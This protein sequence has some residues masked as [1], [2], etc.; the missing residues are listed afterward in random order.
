MVTSAAPPADSRSG[1]ERAPAT[2]EDRGTRGWARGV[3]G[4]GLT[5]LLGAPYISLE[6]H[7]DL[8]DLDAIHEEVCLAV[9]QVPVAYTGGSH[10]SMGIMPPGR[11]S[12]A[13]RDYGEVI[14][15]LDDLQRSTL[16]GLADFPREFAARLAAG[17]EVGE[18]RDLPLNHR[19]MLWLERRHGV[20]F[21]WKIYVELMPNGRWGDK[22]NADGKRFTRTAQT[23]FPRTIAWVRSL[24]F[25]HVGR[26]N[27]MGLAAHD[28]GTVHRDVVPEE[29]IEPDHFVTICPAGNK[30]L[31]LW[32][33]EQRRSHPVTGRAYWFNDADDHGVEADPFFRYSIRIDGV[34]EPGFLRRLEAR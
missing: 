4:T 3:P 17:V 7:L 21:P 10:R 22:A 28:H 12:E 11:E 13:L 27:V 23:Y 5:G 6:E 34:F 26:C 30:R 18:E 32:D 16:S 8:G 15:G 20:Y 1:A 2:V 24:P 14:A 29:Q 33:R 31:F 25:L 9:A 19:Q